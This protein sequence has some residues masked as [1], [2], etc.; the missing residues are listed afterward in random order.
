VAFSSPDMLGL[1]AEIFTRRASMVCGKVAKSQGLTLKQYLDLAPKHAQEG[2]KLV[3]ALHRRYM[4]GDYQHD[5]RELLRIEAYCNWL[6][7][8][9]HEAA[10]QT[11]KPVIFQA[12]LMESKERCPKKMYLKCIAKVHTEW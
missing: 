9:A 7:Q 3:A 5:P 11:P 4:K 6:V 8:I 1:I 2:L 10:K 12:H